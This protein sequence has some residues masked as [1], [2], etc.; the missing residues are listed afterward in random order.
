MNGVCSTSSEN[1]YR[2]IEQDKN[3]KHAILTKKVK[4]ISDQNYRE[5]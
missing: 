2:L 5:K 4:K 3:D 1:K